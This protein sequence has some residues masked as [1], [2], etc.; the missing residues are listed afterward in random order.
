MR[1]IAYSDDASLLIGG[2]TRREL[3]EIAAVRGG[4]ITD[5]GTWQ[6]IQ[7]NAKKMEA[8]MLKLIKGLRASSYRHPTVRLAGQTMRFKMAAKYLVKK[9]RKKEKKTRTLLDLAR[10]L[11][12]RKSTKAQSGAQQFS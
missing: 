2:N 9:E 3:K 6:E 7:F 1:V 12:L 8:P 5:W 10:Y 4:L 11:L